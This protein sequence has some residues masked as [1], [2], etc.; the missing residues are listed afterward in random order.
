MTWRDAE[1]FAVRAVPALSGRLEAR[2]Y[3]LLA[4]RLLAAAAR[5]VALTEAQPVPVPEVARVVREE[6]RVDPGTG[7]SG[8]LSSCPD[9][10]VVA[11][12]TAVREQGRVW[13]AAAG[14]RNVAAWIALEALA[15]L[16]RS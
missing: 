10:R 11:E 16:G 6:L 3:Q 8:P 5:H 4:R 2:R 13:V 12:A 15:R 1:R 7:S 14:E 9:D